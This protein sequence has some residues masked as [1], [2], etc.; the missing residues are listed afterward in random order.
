MIQGCFS[1]SDDVKDHGFWAS[2]SKYFIV[3]RNPLHN[4]FAFWIH[5]LSGL[6]QD[7]FNQQLREYEVTWPQWM[8]LN[9]LYHQ[10]GQTP[11]KVAECI[12]IDRSAITDNLSRSERALCDSSI[13]R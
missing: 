5:R 11:A 3:I 9:V 1:P 7:C 6:M 2:I 8:V 10:M 13:C 4:S 12:G